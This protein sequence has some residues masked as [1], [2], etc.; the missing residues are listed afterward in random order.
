MSE[1]LHNKGTDKLIADVRAFDPTKINPAEA[2]EV[3]LAILGQGDTAT[4]VVGNADG[5]IETRPY[6]WVTKHVDAAHR[7]GFQS[8]IIAA[9]NAVFADDELRSSDKARL[10]ETLAK[11]EDAPSGSTRQG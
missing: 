3:P 4:A 2:D 11:L 10:A 5:S 9:I 7:I 6:G 1:Y 8:G